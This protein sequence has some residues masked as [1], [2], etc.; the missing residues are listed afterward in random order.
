MKKFLSIIIL[1]TL[2]IGNVMFFNFISNT[3]SRDFL[4][5]EQTEVQF[6]YKEDYQVSDFNN[7]IKTFSETKNINIAQYTFLDERD[8][9]IYA[10][11][12]QYSPN[13]K[14]KK[15]DYPDKNRFLA[16]RESGDEKQSGVIYHPS[17]YWSLK[18]YDFGQIKNVGLSDT[19]YVS[20]LDNQDTYQAFLK[21]FEQYGEITTKN[22]DVSWWKYINIPLLMT[23]LLCFAILFVFTYYYLRYS[24]QRLLVNRIWGNS[25]LV[26]LMSLFNKTIIFTLFS[27]L[28]ILITFVSIV[29]ANGLATYLVEIVWKLLLFNVLLF[30]FILFQMYFFGLLRIKKIDQ[31]K[32][33]QRMQSSRQHLAIN[34]VI[35]FV[36]LCLFIGTFIAS[37]QSLQTLNTRLANI[38]VWD[39]TK[40][41]FKVKV[42]VLP[43]GIQDDLKADKELNDNLSAFYEEGT[44]KKEMFLMYSNN[45]QRS[46]T[47][48]FF[49][50][51]YLKKD[52]EINSP[53]GNSVEIDFNYL[54]LN[55]IKSI[56]G[57]NVEKEA[58]ISDKVLNIIVPNGK[59]GL[60][61]DIKNTFLDYFYF[62]KVEVAN[63]YNEALD[64]PAVAL[65][66]EDLS[67]NIIY[68]ENNQDYFSYD[69]NTGDFRTGNIT[70]PI[71]IVYTGNIDSSSI[72]AHVTSSVYFVDKSKGDAFNAILP[73][74]NN[75][76]AREIT[77]VRSVYQEVS[78]EITTLKWQIYQQL[79]GTI[80]LA[81][82][83][84]SFM[85]LLVLSYYREN[86]YKQLIYH[87]FGYSFWKSSK[88]FIISNLFVS[89]FSGILI[90]ILSKEPVALYFSV[91]ILIIELCAIYFIKEKAIYKDFKAILK[92]EKY[93]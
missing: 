60:E 7:S 43:E 18:V 14:L 79:I 64:L 83:L 71:A 62:Q 19:F 3:L 9:N 91:V 39:A 73:L 70:D 87:V 65:S 89:V 66:K 16:N 55:P 63:I 54:K 8:L 56:K 31:A 17:K 74:I 28:A 90:F 80:I 48:T 58:I 81:L 76:N 69:S 44:S 47:N 35:K 34:L 51:T 75:S 30:I 32:S 49:Y 93:D 6:K 57:Q 4:F 67:V 1:V 59:K 61:K 68:A 26:T 27:V 72:G 11:N 12:S 52:S 2:I 37:Y 22:V 24:K 88:W 21:E 5:K 46:E 25:E 42:G 23:L 36:L 78:S 40:D 50:E 53:E 45:F 92:G 38:D 82:C 77:H 33:D 41:I 20:G 10:S 29:L 84:C 13:I 86:L 85:V 15:G